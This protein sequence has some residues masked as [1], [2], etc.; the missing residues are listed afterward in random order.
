MPPQSPL[1]SSP[2][3]FAS[4]GVIGG[5]AWGTALALLAAQAGRKVLLWARETEV[6]QAIRQRH[7]NDPF[8]PGVGL[9]E[10][11]VATSDLAEAAGLEALL[12]VVPAQHLRSVL[13]A[14]S[15]HLRQRQPVVLC[16][17]GIERGSGFLLTEVLAEAAPRA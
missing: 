17:K 15:P 2:A 11:V 5:G 14:L 13:A 4:I 9:P 1:P 3:P 8:L 10:E 12:L 7:R 6:V 16:A